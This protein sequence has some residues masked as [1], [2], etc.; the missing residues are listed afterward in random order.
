MRSLHTRG[1]WAVTVVAF[2]LSA[3]ACGSGSTS[4]SPAASGSAT[5]LTGQYAKGKTIILDTIYRA[6]LA[7]NQAAGAQQA[8]VEAGA[9]VKWVGP[10]D[11]N[12]P[13]GIKALQDAAA[14]GADGAIVAAFPGDLFRVPIDQTGLPTVT[15]DLYSPGSKAS[16][17]F[18]PDKYA[19]GEGLAKE[20]AKAL[21]A[22]ASGTIIGGICVPGLPSL[23][24]PQQGF[25]DTMKKLQPG[26]TVKGDQP[27]DGDATKNYGSWQRIIQQNP[28]AL[29]FVGQCDQDV[30]NLIKLK[31]DSGGPFL[32]GATSGDSAANIA[33]V[34]D[35]TVTAII[36]QDGWVEGYLA[37]R[38]LL[39]NLAKKAPLP[40]GWINTGFTVIT[41][42]NAAAVAARVSN[43]SENAA[44]FKTLLDKVLADPQAASAPYQGC[45]GCGTTFKP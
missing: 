27:V 32:I 22:G 5:A 23:V 39:T 31:K 29:G 26:V 24:A 42:E 4:A 9:T 17:H 43:P 2:S 36:S 12:P 28:K 41:K 40:K 8:A 20:F 10:T 13:A 7:Q 16:T 11:I 33:A 15:I 14:A 34:A 6:P 44:E 18:A 35:G 21:P 30:P 19:L 1:A 37:A 3:T 25:I 38:L 45:R